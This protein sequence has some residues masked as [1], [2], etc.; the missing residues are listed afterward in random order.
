MPLA[1]T[2]E[3]NRAY[4]RGHATHRERWGGMP[5]KSDALLGLQARLRQQGHR[6][7]P[8]RLLILEL[9][10]SYGDHMTAEQI[11]DAA[12]RRFPYINMSTIYRTLDFFRDQGIVTETDLGNDRRHFALL[13]DD[14]HHHL[15]CLSCQ[16]VEEIDDSYFDGLRQTL[17]QRNGFEPRIDHLAIFGFCRVCAAAGH[18]S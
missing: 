17:L 15:I 10:Y 5:Q 8:Q 11:F 2:V 1:A 9:L 3:S 7:T 14:L 6:M 4:P 18:R 12:E 13:S 16:A